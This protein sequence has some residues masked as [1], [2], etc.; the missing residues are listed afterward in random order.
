[1]S[2]AQFYI[3]SGA[4]LEELKHL[5]NFHLQNISDRLDKIEGIRGEASIESDLDMNDNTIKN[6]DITA[7][8]L[9]ADTA[10]IAD[11]TATELA[12]TVAT[13]S[14]HI[15]FRGTESGLVYGEISVEENT[16]TETVITSSGVPVQV[17]VFDTNG[18]SHHTTP[19]HTEDHILIE[20]DGHYLIMCSATIESVGGS[21][22]RAEITI[23]KNNGAS[24]LVP[25]VDRDLAG[26]GSEAGVISLS[27]FAE[28]VE[29]DTVELWIENESNTAN[30]VVEDVSLAILQIGG[31]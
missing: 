27:G 20:C 16:A 7:T 1:M 12:A 26:G 22:S 19:D 18:H 15:F 28:L 17:T 6:V 2:T 23:K 21:G 5:L 14:G 13:F 8:D 4:N 30:Y 3:A 11:L 31:V 29:G 25:H 10:T 24:N 9:T